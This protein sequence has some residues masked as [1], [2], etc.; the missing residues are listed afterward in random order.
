MMDESSQ[1]DL[2]SQLLAAMRGDFLEESEEH[3]SVLDQ[4]LVLLE[5]NAEN[6]EHLEEVFRRIHTVKGTASFTGLNEINKIAHHME[7]ILSA[8]RS[9]KAEFNKQLFDVLFDGL[10]WLKKLRKAEI[11][12]EP[13]PN[14]DSFVKLLQE[15]LLNVREKKEQVASAPKEGKEESTEKTIETLRV[16]T[17]KL[18]TIMNLAGELIISKNKL[19]Q[20]TREYENNTLIDITT[21]IQRISVELHREVVEARLVPISSLFNLFYGILRNLATKKSKKIKFSILGGDIQIDKR[22]KEMLY[23]PFIHILRNAVDHGIESSKD[24]EKVGKK[25]EGKLDVCVSRKGDS[26]EI[27]VSDDGKGINPEKIAKKALENGIITEEKLKECSEADIFNL[28]FHHGF[29]TSEE[30]TETSGRGVGMDVVK[31]NI[32]EMRGIIMVESE[33]GKGTTFTIQIPLSMVI[34]RSLLIKYNETYL[35]IPF[36]LVVEIVFPPKNELDKIFSQEG[37]RSITSQGREIS[38]TTMAEIFKNSPLVPIK[39]SEVEEDPDEDLAMIEGMMGYSRLIP[40][41]EYSPAIILGLANQRVALLVGELLDTEEL[42]MKP[43]SEFIGPIQG[44]AGTAMRPDG[45]IALFLD[46]GALFEYV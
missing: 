33:I 36:E 43:M 19:N 32:A 29:S 42:I 25:A 3:F 9:K 37:R 4:T 5:Q 30:I 22:L 20:Y 17:S 10:S 45:V 14:V 13:T 21:D 40:R 18:D 34:T 27:K 35:A 31:R 11:E 12:N 38:L 41:G 23:D 2:D 8:I 44:I 6:T 39:F 15:A 26:I 24:R 16:R 7:D 28:I 1:N 46:V